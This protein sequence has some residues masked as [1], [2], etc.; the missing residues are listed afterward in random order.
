MHRR[1]PLRGRLLCGCRRIRCP[2]SRVRSCWRYGSRRSG[3]ARRLR[4]QRP[5]RRKQDKEHHRN[6][7]HEGAE[8]REGGKTEHNSTLFPI[9][10][11][12]SPRGTSYVTTL[13]CYSSLVP[14]PCVRYTLVLPAFSR[15]P[16]AGPNVTSEWLFRGDFASR[17]HVYH[18]ID[19]GTRRAASRR[20][21]C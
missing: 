5:R 7:S 20:S 8:R 12:W 16:R 11:T 3:R 19:C 4:Y 15:L 6:A 17:A 9:G 2:R 1:L 13:L 21:P 14:R 18:P 10:R